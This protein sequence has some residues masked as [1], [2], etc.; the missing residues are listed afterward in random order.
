MIIIIVIMTE[1]FVAGVPRGAIQLGCFYITEVTKL[2]LGVRNAVYWCK[3][4]ICANSLVTVRTTSRTVRKYQRY[5][6]WRREAC[7]GTKEASGR[8]YEAATKEELTSE[9]HEEVSLGPNR[10]QVV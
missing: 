3:E 1:D 2:S 8:F 4:R 5:I 7:I 9:I 6:L 10:R